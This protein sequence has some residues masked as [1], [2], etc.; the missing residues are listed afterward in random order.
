MKRSLFF[1]ILSIC[2]LLSA[3]SGSLPTEEAEPTFPI[4]QPAQQE[5]ASSESSFV[6]TDFSAYTPYEGEALLYSRLREGPIDDLEASDSY[7]E[8][9]PFPGHFRRST[10]TDGIHYGTEPSY[11]M[12]TAEGCIIADP[13]YHSISLLKD[14]ITGISSS[15]WQLVKTYTEESNPDED[16]G[17][18]LIYRYG[19]A[20]KDGSFVTPCVYEALELFEDRIFAF[21]PWSGN[22]PLRFDIYDT[23]CNLIMASSEHPLGNYFTGSPYSYTYGDGLYAVILSEG[24]PLSLAHGL[25]FMNQNWEAILGPYNGAWDGFHNGKAILF[26][27]DYDYYFIDK[28]GTPL[29]ELFD[30]L[31]TYSQGFY[32]ASRTNVYGDWLFLDKDLNE[33]YSGSGLPE[34]L[35]NGAFSVTEYN[36]IGD[37]FNKISIYDSEGTFLWSKSDHNILT[38]ETAYTSKFMGNDRNALIHIPTGKEYLLPENGSME[39]YSF[40]DPEDPF[41]CVYCEN[42]ETNEFNYYVFPEN[43]DSLLIKQSSAPFLSLVEAGCTDTKLLAIS[44]AGHTDLYSDSQTCVGTYPISACLSGCVYATGVGIFADDSFVRMFDAEG[45]LVFCCPIVGGMDD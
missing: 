23:D 24:N 5:Q 19:F 32:A 38:D 11:G 12:V 41:I 7:G 6:K 8:I 17:S 33:L 44:K 26:S 42:Y 45:T 36:D 9:Y 30:N 2:V 15:L 27:D 10:G 34:P 20:N 1:L 4:S 18:T 22:D 16:W 21:Y 29:T 25:Y 40:G 39:F 37:A 13:V 3:C 31:Y 14:R 28:N 35:P 43:L